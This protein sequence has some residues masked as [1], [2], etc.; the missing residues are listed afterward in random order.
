MLGTALSALAAMYLFLPPA[1]LAVGDAS[2]QLSLGVFV[3][4]GLVIS[5]LNHRL[6]QAE[7]A[8]RIAAATATARA[9][10]LDAI[11][12]TTVD[13]IIVIDA[14]GSIEAFN[15]GAERLFGYPESEVLGR[16]VSMLM[17]SPQHEEHDG[18]LKRYLDDRRREDHRRGPRGDRP[19]ARWHLVPASSVGRRDADRRASAS[20]PACC[21]T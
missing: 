12:N 19:T 7:A 18:Y 1:G 17:P 16:N 20:S 8:Q 3:A 21:T 6:H 13:G 9:E 14:K 10:R 4:T 15:R 2:D 11:L 5:W